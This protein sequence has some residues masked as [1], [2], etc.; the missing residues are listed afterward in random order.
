VGAFNTPSQASGI[1]H[2]TITRLRPIEALASRP[3]YVLSCV[4]RSGYMPN[5]SKMIETFRR[6]LGD[7]SMAFVIEIALIAGLIVAIFLL[8]VAQ[9]LHES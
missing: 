6:L 4:D 2:L 8:R 1:F 5:L 3:S 9:F 7:E